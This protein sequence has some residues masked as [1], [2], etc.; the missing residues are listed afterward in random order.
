M[1]DLTVVPR[2]VVD[3]NFLHPISMTVLGGPH[4]TGM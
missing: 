3:L 4:I 1:G 2:A